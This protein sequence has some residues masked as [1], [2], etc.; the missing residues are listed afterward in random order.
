MR[1]NGT[2]CIRIVPY[3]AVQFGSYNFYKRVSLSGGCGCSL[4]WVCCIGDECDGVNSLAQLGKAYVEQGHR[5]ARML[6]HSE[7]RFFLTTPPV[8]RIPRRRHQQTA[9]PAPPMRRSRRH[10]LRH[11]HLPTR[12][13]PHPPLNPN[14]INSEHP[15]AET[16]YKTARHVGGHEKHV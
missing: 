5:I 2:N 6:D 7:I 9:H 16:R 14:S 8:L 3:S 4:F 11:L 10:H 13:R 15:S 12:H 1:G